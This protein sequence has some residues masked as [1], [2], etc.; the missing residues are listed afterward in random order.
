MSFSDAL[1]YVLVDPRPIAAGAPYTFF[2]PN[3]DEIAAIASGDLAQL[4]FE[5]VP[6]GHEWGVERM[7]VKV[8]SSDA[9]ELTGT[10]ANKPFEAT[11][12]V[13]EGDPVTF[14]RHHVI[15]IRWANPETAPRPSTYREYWE[16]CLVDDCV[17]DGT[18]PIEFIYREEP[19]MQ[20]EGDK[21][22]DS[23]W[24]VRG[25]M[26]DA[27]DEEADAR[28]PQYVAIGAVLN[29]DDSWVQFVDA[30]VGTR[31]MRDFETNIY[32]KEGEH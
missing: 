27:T 8:D 9:N 4:M 23:G 21:Y 13:R 3:A 32:V 1:G 14:E 22:A 25:R 29:R 24:R 30:P 10:L 20:E 6:A 12:S 15:G 5:H 28:V 2:L 16:R 26:G 18:E 17:L 19:D 7:W 11:A 31:L